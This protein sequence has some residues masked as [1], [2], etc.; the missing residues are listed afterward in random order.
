MGFDDGSFN[1]QS[2]STSFNSLNNFYIPL[3]QSQQ[4]QQQSQVQQQPP[5]QQVQQNNELL[6][7][8]GIQNNSDI[9]VNNNPVFQ[10]LN[11]GHL[12]ADKII[13]EGM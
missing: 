6:S 3:N 9:V 5:T 4:P 8:G 7:S 1:S 13:Y 2:Y 11:L 12:G 10:N